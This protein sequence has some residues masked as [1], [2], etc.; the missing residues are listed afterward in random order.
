M[1]G[2]RNSKLLTLETLDARIVLDNGFQSVF[3]SDFENV[4]AEQFN[5]RNSNGWNPEGAG[6]FVNIARDDNIRLANMPGGGTNAGIEITYEKDEDEGLA[7]VQLG[8]TADPM[9][10]IDHIKTSQQMYFAEDFD[11]A[12]GQK[13]HRL[14][15]INGDAVDFDVIL[16]IFGK[17][18][19]GYAERDMTGINGSWLVT[20]STNHSAENGRDEWSD[21]SEFAFD[22][23]RWYLIETELKLNTPGQSDGYARAWIDGQLIAESNNVSIRGNSTR[24]VNNVGFG[25]WYSNSAAGENPQID[26]AVPSTLYIDNV[27]IFEKADD[28]ENQR[29]DLQP[30]TN[31]TATVGQKLSFQATATDDGPASS[32]SYSLSGEYPTGASIDSTTGQFAWTPELL[33]QGLRYR[34]QVVV[35]DEGTPQRRD[36]EIVVIDVTPE[37]TATLIGEDGNLVLHVIGTDRDES[38]E[39]QRQSNGAYHVHLP[40]GTQVFDETSDLW[41]D[42]SDGSDR[43]V[44]SGDEAIDFA[45]LYNTEHLI[46]T[47]GGNLPTVPIGPDYVRRHNGASQRLRL[48]SDRPIGIQGGDSGWQYVRADVSSSE[49]SAHILQAD[50]AI[51]EVV[52]ETLQNPIDPLDVNH[53][54]TVSPLDALVVV[55]DINGNRSRR[56]TIQH[57]S[58]VA[59]LLDTSG[60]SFV[61]PIDVLHIVNYLNGGKRPTGEAE[62]VE[63]TSFNGER[64]SLFAY[65][66]RNVR[67]LADQPNLDIDGLIHWI[68]LGYDAYFA[69]TGQHPGDTAQSQ[70]KT[71]IARATTCGAGCGY[72]GVRGVEIA[73]DFFDE[74]VAEFA[75]S[76][77]P[78]H[79]FFYEF[80]RNFWFYGDK[81]EFNHA[82]ADQSSRGSGDFFTNGFP[83]FMERAISEFLEIEYSGAGAGADGFESSNARWLTGYLNDTSRDYYSDFADFESSVYTD[84]ITNIRLGTMDFFAEVMMDVARNFG[85]MDFVNRLW[86]EVA[87]R[88]DWQN[89]VSALGNLIASAS[90][91]AGEDLTSRF[92]E[93]YKWPIGEEANLYAAAQAA[94]FGDFAGGGL[95][96]Y[97]YR[98]YDHTQNDFDFHSAQK[99]ERIDPQVDFDW[100][101]GSPLA[102]YPSDDFLVY[103]EGQIFIPAPG[104]YEFSLFADDGV[105]LRIGGQEVISAWN[106]QRAT[107]T[108]AVTFGPDDVGPQSI[109]LDYFEDGG[110][111]TVQLSWENTFFSGIIAKEYLTPDFIIGS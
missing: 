55:N 104:T 63:Y 42:L 7:Y 62:P 3:E 72:L 106:P 74:A 98:S 25:G 2:S 35:Q 79:I 19:P 107:V 40:T 33:D 89:E 110:A 69:A 65:E 8:D 16:T 17:A 9:A 97:Y 50:E 46:V 96:A 14:N 78:D 11:F 68:D 29:P 52:S 76:G 13:I 15:A 94:G 75:R 22:Y 91:A 58:Q 21:G 77:K 90:M 39:I 81:L 92:R 30:I 24:G 4:P 59:G 105:I 56:L 48:D 84:P 47:D 1:P 38:I 66:G 88:R 31:Q 70:G 61:S 54:G 32:L 23:N 36:S 51:M 83:I 95:N 73:P 60:D 53:D 87:Q 64:Y 43:L 111:A 28:D 102:S 49:K 34:F 71:T 101:S 86:K 12:F 80:G 93:T 45:S 108:G 103:W 18:N 67:V 109:L 44:I 37:A 99:T 20:F 100:S 10:G 5:Y 85:G 41:V 27:T 82:R 26:P 57:A 6:G